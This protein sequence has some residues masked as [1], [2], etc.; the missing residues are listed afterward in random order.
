MKNSTLKVISAILT[1]VLLA[2]AV[3]AAPT[4]TT[5]NQAKNTETKPAETT[6]EKTETTETKETESKPEKSPTD[7]TGQW[8]WKYNN[9]NGDVKVRI[10]ENT[11]TVYLHVM[12]RDMGILGNE[13]MALYWH[14]TYTPPTKEGKYTWTSKSL[15]KEEELPLFATKEPTKTF[16]YEN[17]EIS[18]PLKLTFAGETIDNTIVLVP[19][20]ADNGSACEK[21]HVSF[22]VEENSLGGVDLHAIVEIKNTGTTDLYLDEST[23]YFCDEEEVILKEDKYVKAYPKIVAPGDSGY[24]YA[25]TILENVDDVESFYLMW[26]LNIYTNRT[27]IAYL[28][29][30]DAELTEEYFGG[31]EASVKV[32]NPIDQEINPTVVVVLLDKDHNPL[33]VMTKS[34]ETIPAN[35]TKRIEI[36]NWYQPKNIAL[37]DVVYYKAFSYVADDQYNFNW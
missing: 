10:T 3:I 34:Y 16:V 24:Y 17:G 12:N 21:G 1:A 23:F 13:Q 15:L 26:D 33:D 37:D 25:D 22:T 11:V 2:G 30:Y 36:S 28:E 9:E 20:T 18:F 5:N 27:A 31:V 8:H 6:A 32:K 4:P 35:S 29:T 14:G 7:Y 19:Y